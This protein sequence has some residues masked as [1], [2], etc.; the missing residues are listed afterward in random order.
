M[1]NRA[2]AWSLF[3]SSLRTL[4][5][6]CPSL[7]PSL[8]CMLAR[9]RPWPARTGPWTRSWL[10]RASACTAAS[11]A[12]PPTPSP[13]CDSAASWAA[14]PAPSAWSPGP[15]RASLPPSIAP[16]RSGC[17]HAH[18]PTGSSELPAGCSGGPSGCAHRAPRVQVLRDAPD[19]SDPSA[20]AATNLTV[21]GCQVAARSLIATVT[22]CGLLSLYVRVSYLPF[23]TKTAVSCSSETCNLLF[24][25]GVRSLRVLP[26]YDALSW[27]F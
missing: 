7:W 16:G 6:T 14:P 3:P 22:K 13:A 21:Q 17:P 18:A 8:P 11:P 9:A 24:G 27:G 2:Q 1:H 23:V 12:L 25:V 19:G 10:A 4:A 26:A 15:A 5:Y 20:E